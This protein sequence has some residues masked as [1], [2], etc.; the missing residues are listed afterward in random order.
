VASSPP[1]SELEPWPVVGGP[2]VVF[3]HPHHPT[4]L[5]EDVELPNGRILQWLRYAD[6]RDGHEHP[7]GVMGIC[8]EDGAVLLSRQYNP[9]ADRVVW[10]FAGGGTHPG[11]DYEDAVRRELMEEVGHRPRTLRYLGRFL[12]LNRRTGFGIR[13]YLATDLE[14]ASLPADDGEVIEWA[15]VPIPDFEAMIRDGEIDNATVLSGWALL[16]ASDALP[17]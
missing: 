3:A 1:A 4:I 14:R 12:L 2:R 10:E 13:T 7:D 17:A 6:R 5:E 15:F 9:G 8:I 16:R 11:E